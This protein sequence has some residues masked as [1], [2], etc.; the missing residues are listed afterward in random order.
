[1]GI[2]VRNLT[3]MPDALV[4]MAIAHGLQDGVELCEVLIKNKNAGMSGRWG[5]YWS[6]S[7]RKV[8]IT[9]PRAMTTHV[10]RNSRLGLKYTIDSRVEF[11]VTVM[12]HELRHAYQHQVYK[13][14]MA[15]MSKRLLEADAENWEYTSLMRWR[16]KL[17]QMRKAA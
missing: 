11:L 6:G 10:V 13:W 3:D 14:D 1:M 15:R 17:T 9:L 8:V 16:E 12:A 5:T 7:E 2:V 4:T